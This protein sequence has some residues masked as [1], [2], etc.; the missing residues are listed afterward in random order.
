MRAVEARLSLIVYLQL[1]VQRHRWQA[2]REELYLC[3]HAIFGFKDQV[4]FPPS[5]HILA[6]YSDSNVGVLYT[7]TTGT[8]RKEQGTGD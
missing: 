1:H 3:K 7:R 8:Q 4:F 5:L 2:Q 6:K